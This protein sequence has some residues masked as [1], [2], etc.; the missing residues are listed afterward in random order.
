MTPISQQIMDGKMARF[1]LRRLR[2]ASSLIS[3]GSGFYF[4]FGFL[5]LPEMALLDA[6][7]FN[8]GGGR[9]GGRGF[10]MSFYLCILT[11]L[12]FILANPLKEADSCS[13]KGDVS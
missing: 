6:S 11:K 13:F 9:G 7:S 4:K 12:S 1:G 2:A 10:A 8:F 3:E 5:L